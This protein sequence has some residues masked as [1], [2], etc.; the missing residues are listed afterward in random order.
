MNTLLRRLLDRDFRDLSGLTISGSIPLTESLL[1]DVLADALAGLAARD[2]GPRSSSSESVPDL[3]PFARL[4]KT[5]HV[6]IDANAVT[7]DFE[8]SVPSG[9]APEHDT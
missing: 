3:A 7:L 9:A 1:N 5:A 8:L 6:R 4:V 2:P